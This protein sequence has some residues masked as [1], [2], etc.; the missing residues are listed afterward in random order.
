[1]ETQE[2]ELILTDSDFLVPQDLRPT[3]HSPCIFQIN[4]HLGQGIFSQYF[5]IWNQGL[6][7]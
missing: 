5:V 6:K 4:F 7:K 2:V 3:H 1:M